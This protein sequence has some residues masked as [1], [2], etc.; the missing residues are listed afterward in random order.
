MKVEIT[1]TKRLNILGNGDL[2]SNRENLTAVFKQWRQKLGYFTMFAAFPAI[3]TSHAQEALA[4]EAKKPEMRQDERTASLVERLNKSRSNS[5]LLRRQSNFLLPH[6]K[7]NFDITSVLAGGDDCP[8]NPVPAGTYT[9]AAPFTDT[10]NTTGANNT[11]GSLSS[12]Y[13]S[14][15]SAE[16]PDQ[17]YSFTLTSRGANP[18]IQVS[19]TSDTY[20]PLIYILGGRFP[21]RCPAGTNNFVSNNLVHS[22]AAQGG[23]ATLN[24]QQMNFLPLNVPLY[25]F[26]DSPRSGA[27]DSGPYTLRMQDVGISPAVPPP[28]RTRFDFDGDGKADVSVFRPSNGTWYFQQSAN[29]FTGLQ[30][31]D[32]TDK[33]VPAD[34]DGDGKTDIAVF[35]DGTWYWVN[36]SN[37]SFSAMQFGLANDIPQPADFTGDGRAELAVYRA[38]FWYT[39]NLQNNQFNAVPFGL[40]TDKPV[41]G[42]YDGDSRADFAVYRDGT[43]YLLRSQQGFAAIQFGLPTDKLVPADY[44]NDGVT[45]IAVY[46]DGIWYQLRSQSAFA[47]FQFGL[48]ADVPA[49][50]DYDGDGKADLAV[51]REGIWYLLQ[52]TNG[53]AA[54]PFGLASDKPVPSAYLP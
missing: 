44:D 8:G 25:L 23:T 18:Q 50:A 7:G 11:V 2:L 12:Y 24:S 35:R 26:I 10:G 32:S 49:P 43:W 1:N 20:S 30:F 21:G 38:G 33:L 41:V 22:Y 46:R 3:L 52:S 27:N 15:Y 37:S 36:S 31:G 48:A 6:Q 39:L 47:A 28:P 53:F 45:D 5:G 4:D 40:S 34:Y 14:S 19:A 42:D 9:A 29:G 17:I 13:Y 51:Y 16:G 54:I